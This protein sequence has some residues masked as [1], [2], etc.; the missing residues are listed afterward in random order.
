M[1]GAQDGERVVPDAHTAGHLLV[2][3]SSDD[4][5]LLVVVDTD[6]DGV[7][8]TARDTIDLTRQ[9]ATVEFDG[10]PVAEDAV[11]TQRRAYADGTD[12]TEH[13]EHR[14]TFADLPENIDH[15]V[16]SFDECRDCWAD[17]ALGCAREVGAAGVGARD[18]LL[19]APSQPQRCSMSVHRPT[20]EPG[21]SQRRPNP[22]TSQIFVA[23][24]A[25]YGSVC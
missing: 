14:L 22:L 9:Y 19:P 4:G 13:H 12:A 15:V 24:L 18:G 5:P 7:T 8:R 1:G 23:I 17:P 20:S 6:A 21:R 2:D 3:A 11:I 10:T 16:R 25:H